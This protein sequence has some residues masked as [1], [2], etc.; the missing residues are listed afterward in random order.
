MK[1]QL[2]TLAF[3]ST[4]FLNV[5]AQKSFQEL[6]SDSKID[7]FIKSLDPAG[8][9]SND[10]S[11]IVPDLK[12]KSIKKI[13]LVSFYIND[14]GSK[15]ST[16]Y[17]NY[18]EGLG[19]KNANVFASQFYNQGY[20]KLNEVF[21]SQSI[22]LLTPDQYLDTEEKRAYYYNFEMQMTKVAKMSLGFVNSISKGAGA[23][24]IETSATAVGYK[25]FPASMVPGDYRINESLAELAKTLGVDAVA[26]VGIESKLDGSSVYFNKVSLTIHGENPTSKIEGKK[27]PGMSYNS[28]LLYGGGELELKKPF[29]YANYKKKKFGELNIE[30]FGDVLSKLGSSVVNRLKIKS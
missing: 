6:A 20:T 29:S 23:T 1:K 16:S 11:G 10:G 2:L 3:I 25:L 30:G 21:T 26:I 14:S 24:G 8:K 13:A 7:K 22:E 4:I 18:T 19:E 9:L 15:G 17:Y 27:Y 5:Y 28:G 12:I